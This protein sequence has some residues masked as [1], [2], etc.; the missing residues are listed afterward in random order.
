[1]IDSFEITKLNKNGGLATDPALRH[2]RH[3]IE[4]DMGSNDYGYGIHFDCSVYLNIKIRSL[5][6]FPKQFNSRYN[7]I[8]F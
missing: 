2:N 3:S 1:M 5:K 4:I 6:F 8:V 7:N